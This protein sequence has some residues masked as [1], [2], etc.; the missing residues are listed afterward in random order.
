M[1][2]YAH[3]VGV[4]VHNDGRFGEVTADVTHDLFIWETRW[5]SAYFEEISG[6]VCLIVVCESE[7]RDF[8]RRNAGRDVAGQ[9]EFVDVMRVEDCSHAGRQ[10]HH[11]SIAGC[12]AVAHAR[13]Q[14][15]K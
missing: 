9:R 5:A 14:T 4:A 7:R 2:E 6:G 10:Y 8:D 3:G 15:V 12:T 11:D 1:W 13:Q